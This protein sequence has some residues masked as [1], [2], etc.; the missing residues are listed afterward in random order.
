MGVVLDAT[1]EDTTCGCSPA[2]PLG[3]PNPKWSSGL[4]CVRGRTLVA[5]LVGFSG[6]HLRRNPRSSHVE[7]VTEEAPPHP[8]PAGLPREHYRPWF[9]L[10]VEE[11]VSSEPGK[12]AFP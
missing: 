7:G 12:E 6:E 1:A 8:A 10:Q 2:E 11:V 3:C 4:F 5:S 9:G